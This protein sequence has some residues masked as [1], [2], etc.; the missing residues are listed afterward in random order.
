MRWASGR[1]PSIP[2][3]RASERIDWSKNGPTGPMA[4]S[5][6]LALHRRAGRSARPRCARFASSMGCA[7]PVP[8]LWTSQATPISKSKPVK[9]AR[10]CKKRP[11]WR[12]GG[13]QPRCGAFFPAA[14]LR[15]PVGITG[16]RPVGSHLDCQDSLSL[17]GARHLVRGRLTTGLVERP[18]Q[19]KR[20][21]AAQYRDRQEAFAR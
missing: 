16:H 15:T 19:S 1:S 2:A 21:R 20:H 9:T 4:P 11:R 12:A 10:R 18:P 8:P 3:A 5:R 17:F 14:T 7:P 6:L 13:V